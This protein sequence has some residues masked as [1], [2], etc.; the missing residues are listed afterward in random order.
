MQLIW[1]G[2]LDAIQLAAAG[3]RLVLAAAWRSFWISSLAVLTAAL[4]GMPLGSFLARVAFPG[5]RLLVTSVRAAMAVPTVFLGLV[6]YSLLSRRG[7]LGDA[8][9]LYTP[10]AIVIGELMLAL[11]I[12]IGLTHGA[13]KSLD[14][15]VF[16]TAATLG[17]GPLFRWFTYLSE[18]RTAVIL[19]VMTAFARC[20]T[21]LGI[22]MM[23]GGNLKD[24]T[25]T[26]STATAMET[27]RGEFSRGLAMG[28]LLLLIAL[29]A[30]VVIA[31]LSR[32]RDRE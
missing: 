2:I 6:C 11:P 9:F 3:D 16:E 29:T 12:I 1:Q 8:D 27:G 18:A 13:I 24:R 32:E 17:A 30:T 19:A 20:V 5:R 14:R 4:I 10:W 28:I 22:A 26:L 15:R 21:E 7:P 25:R 23:V 31:T